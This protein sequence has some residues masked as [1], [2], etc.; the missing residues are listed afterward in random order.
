MC[1][2]VLLAPPSVL[3]AWSTALVLWLPFFI[4][5][6]FAST[7]NYYLT[8][9]ICCEILGPSTRHVY[10]HTHCAHMCKTCQGTIDRQT[11]TH[12]LSCGRGHNSMNTA[13]FPPPLPCHKFRII[14]Q[15]LHQILGYRIHHLKPIIPPFPP[16][17]QT[18]HHSPETPPDTRIQNTSPKPPWDSRHLLHPETH[19]ACYAITANPF[20]SVNYPSYCII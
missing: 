11:D 1:V 18:P 12:T 9:D 13:L 8:T 19:N 15:S 20:H 16:L 6:V 14:A 17:T 2:H 5:C 10:K 3:S 4:V 7:W